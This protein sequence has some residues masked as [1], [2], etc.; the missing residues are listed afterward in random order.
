MRKHIL[1]VLLAIGLIGFIGLAVTNIKRTNTKLKFEQVEVKSNE[2]KLIELNIKY[3]Q[4]LKQKTNTDAEKQ[5]QLKKIQDLE[6]ERKRL[7]GELQAKLNKES[8]DRQKLAVAAQNA[9]GSTKANATA[10]CNTGNQFKDYI[11]SHESGCR[12]E[13]VNSIGCRGIGQACPG[14]KLPCGADFACQDAYFTNYAM[15]RYGSWEA[16]YRFWVANR[17]W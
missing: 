14:S 15:T 10:G 11:Y 16:A 6:N 12:P 5:E 8:A 2:A 13:A 1:T 4:L 9:S 17:W 3:D 7:E